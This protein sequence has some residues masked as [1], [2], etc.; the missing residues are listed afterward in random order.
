MIEK[1]CIQLLVKC[2]FGNIRK[3]SINNFQIFVTIHEICM[4]YSQLNAPF[5]QTPTSLCHS[6]KEKFRKTPIIKSIVE[7]KNLHPSSA[8]C[9]LLIISIV[10]LWT[11]FVTKKIHTH[12]TYTQAI[13]N[14]MQPVIWMNI[15][16]KKQKTTKK[17]F[18]FKG[19]RKL[20]YMFILKIKYENGVFKFKWKHF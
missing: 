1:I 7:T 20:L 9:R 16:K 3:F 14:H 18:N 5:T 2:Y 10:K 6:K 19:K 4:K 8:V 17:K 15:R 11:I 13:H 12:F